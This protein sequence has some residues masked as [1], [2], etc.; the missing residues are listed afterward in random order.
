[1]FGL[2]EASAWRRAVGAVRPISA[3]PHH[4]NRPSHVSPASEIRTSKR[5]MPGWSRRV[6]ERRRGQSSRIPAVTTASS[7]LVITADPIGADAP[8]A[9]ANVGD[10]ATGLAA[11]R[12]HHLPI[13]SGWRPADGQR[14]GGFKTAAVAARSA[15]SAIIGGACSTRTPLPAR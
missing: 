11:G 9:P 2:R 1:M 4:R 8:L 3:P 13:D 10:T 7:P 15:S 6:K 12:P 5:L 14:R